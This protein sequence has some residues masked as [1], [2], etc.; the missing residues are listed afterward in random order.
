MAT[1]VTVAPPPQRRYR[2]EPCACG[3]AIR[4]LVDAPALAVAAH[5]RS[6]R[7]RDWRA[8]REYHAYLLG[9]LPETMTRPRQERPTAR[10]A[11]RDVSG[12][13]PRTSAAPVGVRR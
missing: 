10:T 6:Q 2:V 11:G 7:H 4:G 12:S 3:G 1:S 8:I 9:A 5:N 13:T